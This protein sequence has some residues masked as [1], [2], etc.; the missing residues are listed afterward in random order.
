ITE[1][2][3]IGLGYG[4]LLYSDYRRLVIV[5]LCRRPVM[6]WY[7]G[8]LVQVCYWR[9]LARVAYEWWL[10]IDLR[11]L[12]HNALNRLEAHVC[13]WRSGNIEIGQLQSRCRHESKGISLALCSTNLL[14]RS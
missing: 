10:V 13:Q 5:D 12:R 4:R 8:R 9:R 6:V 14:C 3:Y 2:V 7:G 11:R 1:L